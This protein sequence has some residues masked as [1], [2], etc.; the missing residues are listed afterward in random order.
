MRELIIRA[1]IKAGGWNEGFSTSTLG[2]VLR[3]TMEE[4][5]GD[6]AK[7]EREMR[8]ENALMRIAAREWLHPVLF[9]QSIMHA[10]L[11]FQGLVNASLMQQ[12]LPLSEV[13]KEKLK[14][15]PPGFTNFFESLYSALCT[16]ADLGLCLT[17]LRPNNVVVD[18]KGHARLIDL[19]V[20]YIQW[21]DEGLLGYF[22]Q[23]NVG[24]R[25]QNVYEQDER[26]D[27][28]GTK[29]ARTRGTQL[30]LMLLLM[31]AHLDQLY[32][33]YIKAQQ[34][35]AKLHWVL[36]RSCVPVHALVDLQDESDL[37]Q[38][39]ESRIEH[40]FDLD[41]KKFLI[42][43]VKFHGLLD[44]HCTGKG[45]DVTINRK[46]YQNDATTC[47][48]GQGTR[49]VVLQEFLD[50]EY[51][52][53]MNTSSNLRRYAMGVDGQTALLQQRYN[54]GYGKASDVRVPV[55]VKGM[56]LFWNR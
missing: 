54:H 12:E 4:P 37:M 51:P 16:I 33:Q 50:T 24:R 55:V 45:F 26:P 30:Y 48:Q 43:Y 42:D 14:V 44:K 2:V 19:G 17:D 56:S 8:Y 1:P 41:L 31:F 53:K 10:P 27:P 7:T 29:C 15:V 36:S 13:L 34:L 47:R 5:E 46:L 40:Y 25:S 39:L 21:M 32:R 38:M 28:R 52:C 18:H 49:Q 20:D 35:K 9:A 11:G 22:E 6:D 3:S 23:A